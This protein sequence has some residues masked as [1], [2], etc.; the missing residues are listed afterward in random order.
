MIKCFYLY[1]F[2]QELEYFCG[3]R[4]IQVLQIFEFKFYEVL[5]DELKESELEEDICSDKVFKFLYSE[6][7][8]DLLFLD[9]ER[10][11]YEEGDKNLNSRGRY[12]GYY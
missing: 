9:E 10:F 6:E 3:E 5:F 4:F 12:L 1:F 7:D 8:K 11:K 2:Y